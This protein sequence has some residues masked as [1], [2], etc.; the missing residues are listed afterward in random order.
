M[1]T[2]EN[3]CFFKGSY[4]YLHVFMAKNDKNITRVS[5]LD[6]HGFAGRQWPLSGTKFMG[7]PCGHVSNHAKWGTVMGIYTFF[8]S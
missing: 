4:M 3:C 1:R 6:L 7:V 8:F 5:Q 2:L